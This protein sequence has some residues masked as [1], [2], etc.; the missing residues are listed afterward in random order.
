MV[1]ALSAKRLD[2]VMGRRLDSFS[3]L[4]HVLL[5]FPDRRHTPRLS[6][7]AHYLSNV[8]SL[9]EVARCAHR[10]FLLC[11]VTQANMSLERLAT[12]RV[13]VAIHRYIIL[14]REPLE[15]RELVLGQCSLS[16]VLA[17]KAALVGRFS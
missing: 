4:A 14:A 11:N 12:V 9:H 13:E 15:V 6:S 8:E 3:F 10:S 17:S 1:R 5:R 2:P 16:L 7:C